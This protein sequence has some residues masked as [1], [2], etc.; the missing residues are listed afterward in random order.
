MSDEEL[1]E[2]YT[3]GR[4]SRRVFVRKLVAGGLSFSAAVAYGNTLG[5][6]PVAAD[7]VNADHHKHRHRKDDDEGHGRRGARPRNDNNNEINDHG[8]RDSRPRND[9]D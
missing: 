4:I 2:A 5:I 8:R 3:A 1:I 7:T 6:T 9:N